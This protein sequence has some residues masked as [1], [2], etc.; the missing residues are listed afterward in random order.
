MS[1]ADR[2]QQKRAEAAAFLEKHHDP[3]A[4]MLVGVVSDLA[5]E[6]EGLRF[7]EQDAAYAAEL[8]FRLSR[9]APTDAFGREVV[10]VVAFFVALAIVG[11][12]RSVMRR[13]KMRD[14]TLDRLESRL[15]ERGPKMATAARKRLERR[16]ARLEKA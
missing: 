16:I 14:K 8:A 1:R 3:I 10:R 13:E 5:P 7:F 6:V 2:R 9:V 11:I 4:K 12:Y 15:L